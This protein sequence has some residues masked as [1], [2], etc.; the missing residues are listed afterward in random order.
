VEISRC[1]SF[2]PSEFHA[3]LVICYSVRR[4]SSA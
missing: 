2:A 1:A 3:P 4:R